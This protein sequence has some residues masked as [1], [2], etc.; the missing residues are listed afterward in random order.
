MKRLFKK[1]FCNYVDK[2]WYQN[3]YEDVRNS[4]LD[5]NYHYVKYGKQERRIPN[6]QYGIRSKLFKIIFFLL[7]FCNI[8]I[9]EFN[10]QK[11][12][13]F[14]YF[15]R[16]LLNSFWNYEYNFKRNF[17]TQNNKL[18]ITSWVGGG[19]ADVLPFYIKRDL[20]KFDSVLVVKSIKDVSLSK[21]PIFEIEI[22]FNLKCRS[23]KFICPI[24]GLF[25]DKLAHN[26]KLFQEIAIH[27][28]FGFEK[29]LDFIL[30]NFNSKKTFYFHDYYLF[31]SNWSFF[32][33]LGKPHPPGF[34][35]FENES[36]TVWD[37]KS[38]LLLLNVIDDIV[39][40]S[41]HT[42]KFLSGDRC[43]P[44]NKLKFHYIP[45]KRNIEL[46]PVKKPRKDQKDFKIL[47]LGNLGIYKGLQVL[48]SLID[49]IAIENSDIRFFHIGGVSEGSLSDRIIQYG[50]LEKN[51]RILRVK[52][53][54]A[55][56]ALVPAQSPETYS[57]ILSD[58]MAFG[59]PILASNIG[60]IPERLLNR[61]YTNLVDDYSNPNSWREQII[62]FQRNGFFDNIPPFNG[63]KIEVNYICEKRMRVI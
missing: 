34:S 57:V 41:F 48:N 44:K 25:L 45:E 52:Q 10:I 54:D 15:Q 42:Y 60:A 53:I 13:V 21:I 1:K 29:M 55:D 7:N 33:V 40:T 23:L 22:Y 16:W 11:S 38:R 63:S 30:L 26:Q 62:T 6:P 4:E 43:I 59:I 28:V 32:K 50:W 27:H 35:F 51:E 12:K 5:P 3:N 36:N 47:I 56:L 58:L 20:E 31:S 18:Y 37:L 61:D 9:L 39:A 49:L 46:T 14:N 24:P 19:V 8:R 17:S 2:I